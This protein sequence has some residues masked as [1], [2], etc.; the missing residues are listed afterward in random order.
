MALR[1]TARLL[2]AAGS[3]DGANAGGLRGFTERLKT[4]LFTGKVLRQDLEEDNLRIPIE[5]S[6]YRYP[7]PA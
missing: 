1:S 4:V 2:R 7:S 3:G 6:Q 5:K